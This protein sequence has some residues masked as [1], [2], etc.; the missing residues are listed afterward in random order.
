MYIENVGWIKNLYFIEY[1][2]FKIQMIEYNEFTYN[3]NLELS[4]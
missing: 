4:F 1:Q 2:F 3:N